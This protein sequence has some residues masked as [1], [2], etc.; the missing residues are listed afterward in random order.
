MPTT[1]ITISTRRD[2]QVIDITNR[3]QQFLSE[4]GARDGLCNV[5]VTHT[6]ACVTTGE[7]IEG[8]DEDLMEVLEKMIP[9]IRFRHAHDPSHA[10]DHM[11]SSILGASLTVPVRN[12]ELVL[13]TWQRVLFVE[14]NGPRSRE[15]VITFVQA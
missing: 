14:C 2:K 7:A 1:T 6:T 3:V 4:S 10:P 5:F 11:I 8:T 9:A 12:G 13:G 15:V